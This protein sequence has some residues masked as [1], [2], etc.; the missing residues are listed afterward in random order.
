M[1]MS[2]NTPAGWRD[3]DPSKINTPAGWKS[4]EIVKVATPSGWRQVWPDSSNP[5]GETEPEFLTEIRSKPT[6]NPYEM[7]LTA[8]GG[9]STEFFWRCIQTDASTFKGPKVITKVFPTADDFDMTC[10]DLNT[11]I[12]VESRVTVPKPAEI[13][14]YLYDVAIEYAGNHVVNFTALSGIVHTDPTEEA[15]IFQCA[16]YSNLN[17]YVPKNFTKTFPVT[18]YAKYNCTLQDASGDI[19]ADQSRKI[20]FT[21]DNK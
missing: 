4:V 9:N 13:P 20:S 18:S 21:V 6:G 16:E 14:P 8:W 11:I 17:G 12:L 2:V 7:E 10:Q 5:P 1:T 19:T 15:Y 3:S